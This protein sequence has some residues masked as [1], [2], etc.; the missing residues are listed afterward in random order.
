MM[1]EIDGWKVGLKF[2]ASHFIPS[3]YKCSRIHGHDYGVRIRIFGKTKDCILYDF[4]ALKKKVR[5]ICENLDHKLIIPQTKKY[6]S[7]KIKGERIYVH[8]EDKFY[9]FPKED[10][11]VIPVELATAEELSRYFS[12]VILQSIDFP[13]NV[14]GLEVCIDEG[15]GQGACNYEEVH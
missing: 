13:E 8:F 3:H 2:S 15:P 4:V 14:K 9:T 6:I 5:E 11:V 7:H 10:V 12:K 1:L